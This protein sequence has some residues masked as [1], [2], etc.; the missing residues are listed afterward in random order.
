[1]VHTLSA[2]GVQYTPNVPRREPPVADRI[3]SDPGHG[4][5]SRINITG[6][7]PLYRL[8]CVRK[9]VSMAPVRLRLS[10]SH[11]FVTLSQRIESPRSSEV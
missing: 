1:M 9:S 3:Q 6:A 2:H 7:K 4:I 10:Q 5:N 11:I 8:P